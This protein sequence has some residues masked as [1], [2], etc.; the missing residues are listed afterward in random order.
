MQSF[1]TNYVETYP[2]TIEY[3]SAISR[4]PTAYMCVPVFLRS[5]CP[6]LSIS[7]G[8]CIPFDQK[9]L[10]RMT[11]IIKQRRILLKEW[12]VAEDPRREEAVTQVISG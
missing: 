2:C 11:T 9:E 3:T 10:G 4:F 7:R 5:G 1:K 8:I 12:F 6:H